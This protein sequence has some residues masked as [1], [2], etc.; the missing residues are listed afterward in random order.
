M[1]I[2]FPFATPPTLRSLSGLKQLA[3]RRQASQQRQTIAQPQAPTQALAQAPS[4]EPTVQAGAHEPVTSGGG[5]G[6]ISTV[7][8]L[9]RRQSY[10]WLTWL[11]DVI[12]TLAAL[13]LVYLTA[14]T[15]TLVTVSAIGLARLVLLARERGRA[16]TAAAAAA[17]ATAE[18]A[19]AVVEG[20]EPA[21]P[22]EEAEDASPPGLGSLHV[23]ARTLNGVWRKDRAA[24][25]P[26]DAAMDL[27]AL[28]PIVRRA[29]RLVNGLELE[30]SDTE[31]RMAVLCAI[32]WFKVRAIPKRGQPLAP[33]TGRCSPPAGDWGGIGRAACACGNGGCQARG[34]AHWAETR[35]SVSGL[36]GTCHALMG[37][38]GWG[39][40]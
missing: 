31:F 11:N 27:V 32:P 33:T 1:S 2:P 16:A 39:P 9:A 23:S 30:I 36:S 26:M 18:A 22:A 29:V 24:S 12:F 8:A 19:S 40:M 34:A 37:R 15:A 35:P 25:E 17:V 4:V 3:K 20:P 7:K 13:A 10:I 5:R 14:S 28:N 38:Q 21:H 6:G